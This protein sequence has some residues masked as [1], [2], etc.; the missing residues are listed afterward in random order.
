MGRP[1]SFRPVRPQA[2][3]GKRRPAVR[4][5]PS[6]RAGLLPTGWLRRGAQARQNLPHR[7]SFPVLL[8]NMFEGLMTLLIQRGRM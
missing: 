3:A 1:V 2:C 4:L 7:P 6:D 8:H 5:T